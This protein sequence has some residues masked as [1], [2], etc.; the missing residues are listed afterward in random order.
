M[1]VSIFLNKYI[2]RKCQ[3]I[4]KLGTW[5]HVQRDETVEVDYV[6]SYDVESPKYENIFFHVPFSEHERKESR[7]LTQQN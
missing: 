7:I 3:E 4:L 6:S 1:G 5:N 2:L